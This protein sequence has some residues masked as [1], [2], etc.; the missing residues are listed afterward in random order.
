MKPKGGSVSLLK[1]CK[2]NRTETPLQPIKA[3]LVI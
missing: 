2:A 3:A 1:I